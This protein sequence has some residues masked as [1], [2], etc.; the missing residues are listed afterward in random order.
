M[1]E[2]EKNPQLVLTGDMIRDIRKKFHWSQ[3]ELAVK[4]GLSAK[5]GHMTIVQWENQAGRAE[6]LKGETY[7]RLVALWKQ[8]N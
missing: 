2:L 6:R 4:C 1:E 3:S 7:K 5:Y 8:D